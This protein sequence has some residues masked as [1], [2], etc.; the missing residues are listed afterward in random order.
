MADAI[1]W[2]NTIVGA[3]YRLPLV[4]GWERS[5]WRDESVPVHLLGTGPSKGEMIFV[6]RGCRCVVITVPILQAWL[7]TAS[8]PEKADLD[9]DGVEVLTFMM[10]H[11]LG[12]IAHGEYSGFAPLPARASDTNRIST[13]DKTRE[14][15]ADAWAANAVRRA[16][17]PGQ[18]GF[19]SSMKVELTLSALTWNLARRRLIDNFGATVLRDPRVV[20]DLGYTHPNF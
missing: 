9:V 19:L 10:L 7:K 16:F 11:E 14:F 3:S 13:A 6:P 8:E 15:S 2:T 17:T 12:H 5:T 18:P 4:P 1:A 20:F